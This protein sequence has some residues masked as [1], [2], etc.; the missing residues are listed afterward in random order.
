MHENTA[1]TVARQFRRAAEGGEMGSNDCVGKRLLTAREAALYLG[2]AVD[3]TYRMARL[4][5]LPSVR[6]GRALRFDYRA[7]ER[8]IER[9]SAKNLE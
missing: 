8:Y 1:Q 2:L 4:R 3:T 7:L 6:V 9:H 5:E